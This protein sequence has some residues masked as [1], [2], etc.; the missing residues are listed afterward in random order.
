MNS[1]LLLKFKLQNVYPSL[2]CSE[3]QDLIP[4][5]KKGVKK[6]MSKNNGNLAIGIIMMLKP[7]E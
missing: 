4:K 2:Q 5:L 6:N 7:R 3:Y 1:E